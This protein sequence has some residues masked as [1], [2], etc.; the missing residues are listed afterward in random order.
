MVQAHG[1]N[2]AAY[3][4]RT[5][6]HLGLLKTG[7]LSLAAPKTVSCKLLISRCV[8]S[9]DIFPRWYCEV[10]NGTLRAYAFLKAKMLVSLEL[11]DYLL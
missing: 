1:N 2:I 7:R 6:V 4:A 8:F 5:L 9:N 10:P 3:C 11:D